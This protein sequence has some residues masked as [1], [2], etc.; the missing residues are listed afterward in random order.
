M[1]VTPAG[2]PFPAWPADRVDR[3]RDPLISAANV[4]KIFGPRADRIIGTPEADLTRR[5]LRAQTGCTIAV[6][7]VSIEV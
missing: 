7:D 1:S 2:P 6:R 3:T 4:W 5:E